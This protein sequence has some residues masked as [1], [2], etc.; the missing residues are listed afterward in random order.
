[1]ADSNISPGM[2]LS[3][4][5][6]HPTTGNILLPA[7]TVLTQTYIDRLTRQGLEGNLAECLGVAGRDDEDRPAVKDIDA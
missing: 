1:M 5:L 7:G 2:T 6:V 3:K 4:P